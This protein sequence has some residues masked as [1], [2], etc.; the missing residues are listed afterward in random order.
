MTYEENNF[1]RTNSIF[2][3]SLSAVSAADNT[4]I[5]TNDHT[6]NI[7]TDDITINLEKTSQSEN[8]DGYKTYEEFKKAI[9]TSKEG[10][11]IKL[12]SNIKLKDT[13]NI[14]TN[15]ITIDGQGHTIDGD[16]DYRIF[17]I[18]AN[19]VTIQNLK[20]IN[21]DCDEGA[22]IY[23]DKYLTVK[24]C[25]FTN[26]KTSDRGGA[27]FNYNGN[28]DI[29]DSMFKN[30]RASG[31]WGRDQYGGAIY[32]TNLKCNNCTF[33]DNYSND[34]AGAIYIHDGDKT[35]IRNSK[36]IRNNAEL[37]GGAISCVDVYCNNCTFENNYAS[38]LGGAIN[39]GYGAHVQ[40]SRF[41][42]N[43]A[44][45][46]GGAV[47]ID[48]GQGEISDSHFTNNQAKNGG[49]IYSSNID[50]L[51]CYF[52]NNH[53]NDNGG[54]LCQKVD[55]DLYVIHAS[56][57][58]FIKNTA[59]IDGRAAYCGK[60]I[61]DSDLFLNNGATGAKINSCWGGAVFCLTMEGNKCIFE[62]NYA[63]DYGGAT[64]IK[65][66][67]EST[68][69]NTQFT[70]NQAKD[71]NGGAIYSNGDLRVSNCNFTKN[72]AKTDGGAIYADAKVTATSSIFII[73][74]A[75][76][77]SSQCYAGAIYCTNIDCDKCIFDNNHAYD[78]GGAIYINNKGKSTIK[79]SKFTNNKADDYNGGAIYSKKNIEVYN[80]LFKNNQANNS[81]SPSTSQVGAIYCGTITCNNCTFENNKAK[82]YA[83]AIY[84]NDK[85]VS[86]IKNSKFINNTSSFNGGAINANGKLIVESSIF[87]NNKADHFGGAL[88]PYE[89]GGAIFCLNIDCNNSTFENNYAESYGGAIFIKNE[90]KSTIKN[91]KFIN[92]TAKLNGGAIY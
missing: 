5:K 40:N 17:Y 81:W 54:A 78:Y 83:G 82:K 52:E 63:D 23:A 79:N 21:G 76:G 27:I 84:I 2:I 80:S 60:I 8:N 72:K 89:N 67:S 34:D 90:G 85:E 35:E 87:K 73:N 29:S 12:G 25:E 31:T 33:E 61:V 15:K 71:N 7:K 58:K 46:D 13:L 9:E 86:T 16:E 70:N 51:R 24:K 36:F 75:A 65:T 44:G 66:K 19:Y 30:N 10:D 74:E 4:T 3:I 26:N 57:C 53:A 28:L 42:N 22:A 69:K 56:H 59:E 37:S 41:K 77:A 14:K 68:I 49:A 64:Y 45:D 20:L 1:Y 62:N 43:K 55:G 38:N 91:S 18:P 88:E 50:C 48:G 39:G 47:Y 92:N 11:T 32:C 6:D